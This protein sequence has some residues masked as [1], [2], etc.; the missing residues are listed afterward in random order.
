MAQMDIKNVTI[1]TG[2]AVSEMVVVAVDNHSIILSTDY[3][4]CYS[5]HATIQTNMICAPAW[6]YPVYK[7]HHLTTQ[8]FKADSHIPCCSPATTLPFSEST[9]FHTGHCI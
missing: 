3:T 9:L 6:H 7:L 4:S 8:G 2:A 1:Y 5:T